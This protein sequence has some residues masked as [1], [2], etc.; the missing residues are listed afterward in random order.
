MNTLIQLALLFKIVERIQG[1]KKLQ[2]MVH[3]LQS[4]G[5]PFDVRYGYHHF[6]PFSDQLQDCMNSY[7]YDELILEKRIDGQFPTSEFTPSDKLLQLPEK[8]GKTEMP[9]WADFAKDLNERS[10]RELEA[11]STLIYVKKTEDDDAVAEEKFHKLK[12][13]LV[14]LLPEARA[15]VASF[16][17]RYPSQVIAA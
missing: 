11:I 1:R 17:Q 2:K 10:P 7:Q 8:I 5:V 4:F 13:G 16:H 12:P 14:Q 3:I 9:A 15:A 6:G